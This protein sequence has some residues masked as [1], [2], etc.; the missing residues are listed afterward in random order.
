MSPAMLGLAAGLVVL[1]FLLWSD[2]HRLVGVNTPTRPW[3]YLALL[4]VL[5]S[6]TGLATFLVVDGMESPNTNPVQSQVTC[7]APKD[8]LV[9]QGVN[10]QCTT[11]TQP[12]KQ[13]SASNTN[14][15]PLDDKLNLVLT[16]LGVFVALVTA[17]SLSVARN[18]TDEARH[19]E[20]RIQALREE[21][22][23]VAQAK[24]LSAHH[25]LQSAEI[26]A[27]SQLSRALSLSTNS[28]INPTPLLEEKLNT[29]SEMLRWQEP[30]FDAAILERQIEVLL[31]YFQNPHYH[32]HLKEFFNDRDN[33]ACEALIGL[34]KTPVQGALPP[35]HSQAAQAVGRLL[36]QLRNL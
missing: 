28:N 2:R 29:L 23:Y 25:L 34:L 9:K 35:G 16:A 6:V 18:A 15:K 33:K 36:R 19:A 10:L 3:P 13:L 24:Q 27:I 22:D 1:A 31:Q 30:D 14:D 8:G 11:N 5:F 21:L 20:T 12:S 32:R 4:L 7:V 17:I 26:H